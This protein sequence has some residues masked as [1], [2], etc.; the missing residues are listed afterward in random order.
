MKAFIQ[1][2]NENQGFLSAILSAVAVFAAIS[3]PAFIARR[4][5]KIALFEKK[6]EAY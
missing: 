1:W 2:C 4:Q 5:N 3:I 6:Y